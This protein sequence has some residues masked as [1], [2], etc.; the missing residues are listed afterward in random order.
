MLCSFVKSLPSNFIRLGF[1]LPSNFVGLGFPLLSNF[2]SFGFPLLSYVVLG[3]GRGF[4]STFCAE[5]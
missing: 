5:V 2:I 4:G 1:P 3:A